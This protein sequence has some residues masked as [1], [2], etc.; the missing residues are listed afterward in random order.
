MTKTDYSAN[1][2]LFLLG[3]TGSIFGRYSAH[4][5]A[6]EQRELFGRFLGR[7]LIIIDGC[8]ET[9]RHRVRVCFC[10]DFTDTVR[11]SAL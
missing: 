9:I 6:A 8:H 4:M 7:G 11:W 5:T 10:L 1:L 2:A 3:K